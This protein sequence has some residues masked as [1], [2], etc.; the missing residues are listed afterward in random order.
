MIL[1]KDRE[2]QASGVNISFYSQIFRE[3]FHGSGLR[4]L[5]CRELA[6]EKEKIYPD[7][8]NHSWLI[9]TL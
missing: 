9:F 2:G 6:I 5:F 3:E 4:V 7:F 1:T 8:D